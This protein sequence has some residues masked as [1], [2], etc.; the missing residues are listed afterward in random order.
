[1]MKSVDILFDTMPG[2]EGG[3][4]VETHDSET[5]KAVKIGEWVIRDDGLCAL[6]IPLNSDGSQFQLKPFPADINSLPPVV[7]EN[8]MDRDRLAAKVLCELIHTKTRLVPDG[9]VSE[10][11]RFTAKKA[12]A[13]ADA[14]IAQ[15]K[16]V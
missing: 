2:P 15:S 1:M 4:F 6:R 11:A 7:F 13:L 5:D 9:K 10:F 14:M 16:N 3:R 8:P 12:Y